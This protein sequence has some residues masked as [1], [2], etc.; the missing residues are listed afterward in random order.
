MGRKRRLPHVQVGEGLSRSRQRREEELEAA[1][2]VE[3]AK[4]DASDDGTQPPSSLHV[5]N[6]NV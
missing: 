4:A 5:L 2:I 3:Q 1:C 6:C